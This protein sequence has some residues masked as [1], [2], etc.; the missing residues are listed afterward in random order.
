[1][2]LKFYTYSKFSGDVDEGGP[3][4]LGTFW[5]PVLGILLKDKLPFF[6]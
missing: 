1:M 2:I 6:K 4:A 3:G 5:E